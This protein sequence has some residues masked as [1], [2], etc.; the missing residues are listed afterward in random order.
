[1]IDTNQPQST[2]PFHNT[3]VHP[4]TMR[5]TPSSIIS[6][7]PLLAT[8]VPTK[9]GSLHPIFKLEPINLSS[10]YTYTSPSASGPKVGYISFT[11]SND[12]VDYAT[13]CSGVT[14]MPLGQFYNTQSFECTSLGQSGAQKSLFTFDSNTNV[15][16]LNSTWNC[17]GYVNV[18][19]R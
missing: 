16:S 7:F 4:N 12:E 15:L 17:G 1:V 14:S 6:I 11:L 19:R 10:Y 13:Q 9:C 3:S 2:S 5:A 8:A 18:Q